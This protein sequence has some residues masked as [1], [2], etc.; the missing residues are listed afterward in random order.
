MTLLI[1][2]TN[3]TWVL[4]QCLMRHDPVSA[5]FGWDCCTVA[6]VR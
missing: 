4:A 6:L 3:R 5:A 1:T 2:Q